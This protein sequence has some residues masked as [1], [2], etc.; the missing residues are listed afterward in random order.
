MGESPDEIRER[1]RVLQKEAI[2]LC[3]LIGVVLGM[4]IAMIG[5][6]HFHILPPSLR[7]IMLI[8]IAGAIGAFLLRKIAIKTLKNF[9]FLKGCE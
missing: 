2:A 4:E 8:L 3:T 5:E 6:W 7:G 1:N 9:D